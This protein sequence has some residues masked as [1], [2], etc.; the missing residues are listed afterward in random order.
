M[1]VSAG[2]VSVLPLFDGLVKTYFV[3]NGFFNEQLLIRYD[4]MAGNEYFM[5][6]HAFFYWIQ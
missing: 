6:L 4:A 1:I 5:T 2:M 3:K